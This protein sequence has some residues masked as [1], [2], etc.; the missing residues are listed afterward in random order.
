MGFFN[1]SRFREQNEMSDE[2]FDKAFEAIHNDDKKNE[3]NNKNKIYEKNNV[4]SVELDKVKEE[5]NLKLFQKIK[6]DKE[7]SKEQIDAIELGFEKGINLYVIS[8]KNFSALKIK[9]LIKTYE[10]GDNPEKYLDMNFLQLRYVINFELNKFKRAE[11]EG[12]LYQL[13]P[14][15]AKE[16]NFKMELFD[17]INSVLLTKG[18][19]AI[20]SDINNRLIINYTG[21]ISPKGNVR[22]QCTVSE[23]VGAE[24][25][26][27][28]AFIIDSE[29]NIEGKI[30]EKTRGTYKET[31]SIWSEKSYIKTKGASISIDEKISGFQREAAR[32]Q[33]EIARI[34]MEL[35]QKRKNK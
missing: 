25:K 23:G 29:K 26:S 3:E 30:V 31:C 4:G 5:N 8:N 12:M 19:Y 27:L 13:G 9:E 17:I 16:V 10:L 14:E 32:E 20:V 35:M 15:Q 18:S 7:Y 33:A 34:K 28:F 6:K 22:K 2:E 24:V 11:E 21:Y 1:N